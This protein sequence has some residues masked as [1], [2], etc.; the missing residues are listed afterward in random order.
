MT[1][2]LFMSPHTPTLQFS[3]NGPSY[4]LPVREGQRILADIILENIR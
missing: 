1:P 3:E 4:S 2:Y